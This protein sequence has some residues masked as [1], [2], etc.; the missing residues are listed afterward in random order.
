VHTARARHKIKQ[1]IKHEEETVSLQLGQEILERELKKRRLS[2]ADDTRM[3][4]AASSLSLADARG[5]TIAIGRGDVAIGQVVRALFPDAPVDS[6]EAHGVRAGHRP[7][8][9]RAR[10]QDPGCGRPHGPLC[11]AASRCRVTRWWDM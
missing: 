1:W 9:P 5:L 3:E 6:A 8:P 10:H 2:G 7:H 4:R 11:R